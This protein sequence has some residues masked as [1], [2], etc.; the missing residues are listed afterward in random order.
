MELS[1]GQLITG[2]ML[3]NELTALSET[4]EEELEKLNAQFL[5]DNQSLSNDN[6]QLSVLVKEYEQVLENVM[7]KFRV[8]AVRSQNFLKSWISLISY[9]AFDTRTRTRSDTAIRATTPC[10]R[11]RDDYT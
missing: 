4:F 2:I 11:E 9:V 1:K 10:T 5:T 8:Q 6:K 3:F 7:S